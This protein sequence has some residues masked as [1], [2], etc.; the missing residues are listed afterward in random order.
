M[1]TDVML[2]V[3]EIPG[4]NTDLQALM[5]G[6]AAQLRESRGFS[7]WADGRRRDFAREVILELARQDLAEFSSAERDEDQPLMPASDV[8]RL[9][10]DWLPRWW[11]G[12]TAEDLGYSL[13]ATE[14]GLALVEKVTEADLDELAKRAGD[15]PRRGP[16][17]IF[18]EEYD[19][20]SAM[21]PGEAE[22]WMR[23]R[24]D[25]LTGMTDEEIVRWATEGPRSQD[26]DEVP[27][28]ERPP[29]GSPSSASSNRRLIGYPNLRIIGPDYRNF[30]AGG[31]RHAHIQMR[32]TWAAARRRRL[33]EEMAGWLAKIRRRLL[34]TRAG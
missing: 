30:W 28:D 29:A 12:E 25:E 18:T 31:S 20:V 23:Q 8:E 3:G 14:K 34:G 13:R 33:L 32:Q 16:L 11:A 24:R 27:A 4:A 2:E 17:I 1:V 7:G 22:R 15:H 5:V 19:R 6:L 26:L 10:D 9:L 21:A